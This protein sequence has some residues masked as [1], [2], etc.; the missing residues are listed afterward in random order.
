MVKEH[1]N[2]LMTHSK[3]NVEDISGKAGI[4]NCGCKKIRR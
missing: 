4:A 2:E 1:K 3:H